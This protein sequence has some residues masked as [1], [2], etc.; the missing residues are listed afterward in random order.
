[1]TPQG[2]SDG[3]HRGW[4]Q[5]KKAGSFKV[6]FLGGLQPVTDRGEDS[7]AWL[8]ALSCVNPGEPPGSTLGWSR[9]S[10]WTTLQPGLSLFPD[11]LSFTNTPSMLISLLRSLVHA[12]HEAVCTDTQS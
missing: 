9:L 3:P 11:H 1:M 4:P 12:V 5:L 10:F 2:P 8:L 7:K 6:T